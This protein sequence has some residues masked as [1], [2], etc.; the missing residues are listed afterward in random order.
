MAGGVAEIRAHGVRAGLAYD[1][2]FVGTK[3]QWR[4]EAEGYRLDP[5]FYNGRGVTIRLD[6]GPGRLEASG[7]VWTDVQVDG[8][9]H[10]ALVVK[11]GTVTWRKEAT[12]SPSKP[13]RR[14]GGN[15]GTRS[16]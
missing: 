2:T 16:Q 9:R 11:G 14:A 1:W 3:R 8:K 5:L 7:E 4:F 12:A 6:V 15:V 10:S 13:A